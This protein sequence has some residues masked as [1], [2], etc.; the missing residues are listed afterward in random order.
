MIHKWSIAVSSTA[1]GEQYTL[2]A[3]GKLRA[4]TSP[5]AKPDAEP[6]AVS[7]TSTAVIAKSDIPTVAVH[8]AWYA[9]HKVLL[10]A[11]RGLVMAFSSQGKQLSVVHGENKSGGLVCSPNI[12]LTCETTYA[13]L[14][15]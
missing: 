12:I 14:L 15:P 6:K 10:V 4:D 7:M 13:I 5:A 11:F 8:L 3:L 2:R 9:Q 1:H